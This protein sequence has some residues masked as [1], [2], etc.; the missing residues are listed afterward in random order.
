MLRP[1]PMESATFV[2]QRLG[3]WRKTFE[4]LDVI[5]VA[6]QMV[7]NTGIAHHTPNSSNLDNAGDESAP[8]SL[9][10]HP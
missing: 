2:C 5:A 1:R 3:H 10:S 8:F 7:E 6:L 4:S 9:P